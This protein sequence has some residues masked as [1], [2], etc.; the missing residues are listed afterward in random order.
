MDLTAFDNNF[1]IQ[2]VVKYIK[3]KYATLEE[4]SKNLLLLRKMLLLFRKKLVTI[5]E[6]HSTIKKELPLLSEMLYEK[7][8]Y[9]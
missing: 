6:N 8:Y 3:A 9:Y 4:L 2:E 1:K 5:K 7:T